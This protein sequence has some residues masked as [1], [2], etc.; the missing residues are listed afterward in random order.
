MVIQVEA[1][2]KIPTRHLI[3]QRRVDFLGWTR[4]V[5]ISNPLDMICSKLDGQATNGIHL[6]DDDIPRDEL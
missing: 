5:Y 1:R 2:K 4:C 3:Q 6:M